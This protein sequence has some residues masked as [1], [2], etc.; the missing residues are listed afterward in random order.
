MAEKDNA[1]MQNDFNEKQAEQH[2]HMVVV[3]GLGTA[4]AFAN[5]G[6][7]RDGRSNGHTDAAR[8]KKASDELLYDTAVPGTWCCTCVA[9]YLLRHSCSSTGTA[10]FWK[11]SLVRGISNLDGRARVLGS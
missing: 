3:S 11:E 5:G 2:R 7:D 10:V 4:E 6:A 1:S 9:R 8:A